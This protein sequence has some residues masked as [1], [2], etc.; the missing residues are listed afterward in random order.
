MRAQLLPRKPCAPLPRATGDRS[1]PVF[2]RARLSGR[3]VRGKKKQTGRDGERLSSI[4]F[5]KGDHAAPAPVPI[6]NNSLFPRS[7]SLLIAVF[8]RGPL[9]RTRINLRG[10]VRKRLV[11]LVRAVERFSDFWLV[12]FAASCVRCTEKGVMEDGQWLKE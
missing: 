9:D 12:L 10:I 7:L 2:A 3:G 8:H 11:L 1:P 4:S 6:V 5:D